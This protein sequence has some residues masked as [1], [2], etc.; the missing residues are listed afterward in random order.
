MVVL[1]SSL[2]DPDWPDALDREAGV[3][4]YY[5][6]NKRPGRGL[7]DTPRNGNELL[8]RIF[9]DAHSGEQARHR[10][11]PIFIFSNTGEWRDV[12][13]LGLAVPGISEHLASED[14]VAI[15]RMAKGLRFQNYRSHFTVVDVPNVSR[16]WVDDV[17]SANPHSLHAPA[18]W[19]EWVDT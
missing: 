13:F 6:D 1:T 7:H 10:V 3:F 9:E 18:A 8:R 12:M 4:T 2:N 19:M 5:G 16:A 17:I 15:W 11:P 14:L